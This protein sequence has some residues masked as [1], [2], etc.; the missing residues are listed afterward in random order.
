MRPAVQ[1]H[2]GEH[3]AGRARRRGRGQALAVTTSPG[4]RAA[5]CRAVVEVGQSDSSTYSTSS[6]IASA[7]CRSCIESSAIFAPSPA[8]LPAETIREAAGAARARSAPR[9]RAVGA[10]RTGEG[11][12][13][14][15]TPRCRAPRPGLP[16]RRDRGLG[17]LQLS[18]VALGKVDGVLDVAFGAL[19]VEH[20][21]PLPALALDDRRESSGAIAPSITRHEAARGVE[22]TDAEKLAAVDE[23][24]PQM[25]AGST[26]R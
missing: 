14:S 16:A 7:A 24:E 4:R 22:E 17:E 6:N 2:D 18:D 8:T 1:A 3:L 23:P 20:E 19:P 15:R 12:A 9:S 26:S 13:G 11:Y 25:P 5:R 21:D 10:E